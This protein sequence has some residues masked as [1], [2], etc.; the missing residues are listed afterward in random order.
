MKKQVRQNRSYHTALRN[1]LS[2]RLKAAVGQLIRDFQSTLD[3]QQYPRDV[4]MT[5]QGFHQ[6]IMVYRI[7]EFTDVQIKNPRIL[8]TT[9]TGDAQGIVRRTLRTI[10]IG[11]GMKIRLYQR[12]DSQHDR[13]LGDTV[14]NRGN[15]QRT[16]TTIGLGNL[17]QLD[18]RRKVATRTHAVPDL[19]KT[20]FEITLKLFD[21]YT[22]DSGT[23]TVATYLFPSSHHQMA[24]NYIRFYISF[25]NHPK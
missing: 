5:A 13:H 17:Y 9:L 21:T 20:G 12:I 25:L 2:T 6:Q 18:G 15:A 3:I 11:I 10:T 22:V 7:K 16:F 8:P 4:S 24:R 23:T 19:V 14:F 1:A